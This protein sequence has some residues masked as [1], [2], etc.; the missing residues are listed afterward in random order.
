MDMARI[1]AGDRVLVVNAAGGVGTALVQIARSAGAI[2]VALVGSEP[3][4]KLVLELGAKQV[5][6]YDEWRDLPANPTEAFD[7]VMDPRGGAGLKDSMSRLRPTGRAVSFGVSSLVSGPRRSLPRTIFQLLKTPLLTPIGLGTTN[8]GIFGL[9]ML[10]LFD[11]GP[12]MTLLL[13][14]IDKVLEGFDHGRYRAIVGRAFPLREA[15]A[16]HAY[17]QSRASTGKVVLVV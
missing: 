2:V 5:W 1:Q 13:Q 4:K 12:G 15:G 10:K 7:V 6:T 14:A 17:L 11:G 8:R 16:A 3:K 9:N